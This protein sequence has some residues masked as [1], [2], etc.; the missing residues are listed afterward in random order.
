MAWWL[1]L[2]R[3]LHALS[4]DESAGPGDVSATP[5]CISDASS[6]PVNPEQVLSDDDLPTAVHAEDQQQVIRIRDV[7]N[8]SQ[9]DQICDTRLWGAGPPPGVPGG[10]S[11]QTVHV[12]DL[13]PEA[14]ISAI[15]P[16]V[17][18]V[19]LTPVNRVVEVPAVGRM[20]TVP[21][22]TSPDSGQMSPESPPTVAF[23]DLSVSSV[24]MSPN[25]VR[26]DNSQ[27]VPEDGPVFEVSPKFRH[28][29]PAFRCRRC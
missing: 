12:V 22:T 7:V 11:Q 4:S 27:D 1:P 8:L 14:R 18:A 24:P 16:G 17:G 13:S 15:P 20:E 23:E 3:R 6:S 21:L 10:D 9:K 25:C 29:E 26:V 5:I 28:Q 2:G 19:D